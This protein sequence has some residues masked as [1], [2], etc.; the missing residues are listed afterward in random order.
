MNAITIRTLGCFLALVTATSAIAQTR[1]DRPISRINEKAPVVGPARDGGTQLFRGL[2]HHFKVEPVGSSGLEPDKNTLV[3]VIGDPGWAKRDAVAKI[4]QNTLVAG[5]AVMIAADSFLKLSPFFP[6]GEDLEIVGNDVADPSGTNAY[7]GESRFP[8]VKPYALNPNAMK[9]E[10]ELFAGFDKVATN[11][12]T[13][14]RITKRPPYLGRTVAVFHDT[15][16]YTGNGRTLDLRLNDSFAAAGIGTKRDT[17]RCLVMADRDVLTNDML[18][19]SADAEATDNFPFAVKL[20]PWL[21]GPEKRTQCLFIEDGD[22]KTRFDDF[23]FSQVPSAAPKMPPPPM[24]KFPDPMD[25][26][27]Q[28]GASKAASEVATRLEDNDSFKNGLSRDTKAYVA[29]VSVIAIIAVL[30]ASVLLRSR[31]WGSRQARDFQPIPADPLRLGEDAPLGSFAHRRLELLRGNDFRKPFT[32]YVLLLFRER[33]FLGSFADGRRP[34]IEAAGRNRSYLID[35]VRRLWDEV[36]GN[37][38]KPL[39]YTKWKELEPILA[40][41]RVAADADRWRFAPSPASR[42]DSEG[43]A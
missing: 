34:K 5:G 4:V 31:I 41:V 30:F 20:V 11:G 8:F 39:A 18:Y 26:K 22:E 2:L 29:I 17:F 40:A 19:S 36:A 7:A 10:E 24:P 6:D 12:P 35:S 21:R 16:K 3:I 1:I 33:G 25:R 15:A 42:T 27:F 14:L 23:D 43:A 9:P 13:T 38:A 32:E 28:E 37:A